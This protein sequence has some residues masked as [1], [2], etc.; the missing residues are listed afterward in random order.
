MREQEAKVVDSELSGRHSV[1]PHSAVE[2]QLLLLLCVVGEGVTAH[3]SEGY[4]G[5]SPGY[6]LTKYVE[7]VSSELH[8]SVL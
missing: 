6:L 7:G 1:P 2:H 5:T 4:R 3:A 8:S